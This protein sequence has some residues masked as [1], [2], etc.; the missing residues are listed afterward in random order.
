MLLTNKNSKLKLVIAFVFAGITTHSIAADATDN[1]KRQISQKNPGDREGHNMQEVVPR[2]A[3]P[4]AP[5]LNTQD[6]LNSFVLHDDFAL[7]VIADSPLVFDPVVVQYD[8]AGNLWVVEMTTFMPDAEAKGEMQHESQIV[9]LRDQNNDGVMDERQVILEKL[10]LPR[11]LAFVQGG[12]LWADQQKLYFT[13]VSNKSDK[14]TVGKTEVIDGEYA[15]G[16]NVEHKPNGLL[17]S[18]DNWYYSA[19]TDIKYRPY[20]LTADIPAGSE[21]IYRNHLWKMVRARTEFRGQWGISQDDY[22]RH[23]FNFNSSP[24]Q[25]TS[26][27][28]DVAIRNPK[29]KF[30]K[31]ILEQAVGTTDVYPVRVNPGINRG[32][33]DGVLGENYRLAHH[34][35]ACGPLI[36]R[37]NQFPAEYY[38][39]GLVAE[40]AANLVKATRIFEQDSLVTGENLFEKQEILASTDERFRPVNAY[41]APDGTVTLVD[42]YHGII[43]HRTYLTT[44]LRQQITMRELERNKHIG[45]IYRLKHKQS[46]VKQNNYLDKVAVAELVSYLGHD[47]GWHRDMAKQIIVMQQYKQLIPALKKMATGSENPLAQINALWTLEGLGVVDFSLLKQAALSN[48]PKVLSTVYRLAEKLPTN[49][50]IQKWLYQQALVVNPQSKNALELACGTHKAWAALAYII[51]KFALSDFSLAALADAEAAFLAEQGQQISEQSANKI[52]AVMNVQLLDNSMAHLSESQV[53]S[54]NRGKGFYQGA[55]ACFGCHGKDGEG[56][57]IVPPL[58]NSEWVVGSSAR[59]AAILLHGFTGPMTVN[60]QAYNSPMSMPGLAG[61][62]QFSD[63][64]LADIATYIRNAWNNSSSAVESAEVTKV[65]QQTAQQNQPFTTETIQ[66]NFN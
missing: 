49:A 29:H 38:G 47:N 13:E 2:E 11:A 3:I 31:E 46:T 15:A 64:D 14:F 33:L 1:N 66:D 60:G 51:N 21:E 56:S 25:T 45:R 43:Q 34:T 28:P 19:K 37:G 48:Q 8:A 10:L 44:Y 5:I 20:P 9:V 65:R 41:N 59:L 55:A 42:F 61:N 39:I 53:E 40:P 50:D 17:Y 6:A 62:S 24:I 4:P 12:I 23:Y 30:P 18:L 7:E 27:L 26:F 22:G 16:G 58:N 52:R 63:Q 32:Y 35:A 57:A 54:F 36:Y